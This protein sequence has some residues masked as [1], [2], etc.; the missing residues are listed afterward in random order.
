MSGQVSAS[1]LGL[2][3]AARPLQP[4]AFIVASAQAA[5]GYPGLLHRLRIAHEAHEF[6][7]RTVIGLDGLFAD[8][9]SGVFQ[10][11]HPPDE[12]LDRRS[13]LLCNDGGISSNS[14]VAPHQDRS[15]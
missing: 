4:S 6:A 14:P 1:P 13:Q 3:F 12:R 7:G 8:H 11:L 5:F 15:V 9:V 2:S 10:G